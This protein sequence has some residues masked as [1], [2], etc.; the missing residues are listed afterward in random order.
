MEEGRMST[1]E[2]LG[3]RRTALEPVEHARLSNTLVGLLRQAR[4]SGGEQLVTTNQQ[5]ADQILDA[6][7]QVL[8][9]RTLARAPRSKKTL[10][11]MI[12][13]L[14][15][16]RPASADRAGAPM[17]DRCLFAIGASLLSEPTE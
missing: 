9:E 1:I 15:L 4:S 13:S 12:T 2:D 14:G 10:A 7:N 3:V 11:E 5:L 6:V 17:R 8:D 16:L